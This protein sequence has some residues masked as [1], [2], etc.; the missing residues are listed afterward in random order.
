MKE[1]DFY[2]VPTPIGNL[3][4]ITN[5]ALEIL[6]SVDIIACEDIRVTQKLLNHFVCSIYFF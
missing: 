1:F 6:N 5:R 2:I 4:D 3:Q